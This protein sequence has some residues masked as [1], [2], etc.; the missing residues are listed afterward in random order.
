MECGALHRFGTYCWQ[1]LVFLDIIKPILDIVAG[2]CAS[3][4]CDH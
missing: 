4:G 1:S 2:A 3:D